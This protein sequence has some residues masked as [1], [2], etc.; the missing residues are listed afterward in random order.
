MNKSNRTLIIQRLIWLISALLIIPQ[1]ALADNKDENGIPWYQV[2]VII[3]A[4]QSY[5]G[6]SSETWPDPDPL[7]IS[8]MLELKHPQDV[9]LDPKTG[10][11]IQSSTSKVPNFQAGQQPAKP[12][13]YELLEPADLQ[14]V[15][16]VKK[17]HY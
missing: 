12:T 5:L 16:V 17:L 8:E 1:T 10:Q 14:L 4:N 15:P 6:F 7:Q 9:A 2:E 11:P 13:P 3:F